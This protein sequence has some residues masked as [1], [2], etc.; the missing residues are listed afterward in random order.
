[1]TRLGN[2]IGA[3]TCG[4]IM[5]HV[6]KVWIT[7]Y[8][9][10]NPKCILLYQ[11]HQ[12][13]ML[14]GCA[15]VANMFDKLSHTCVILTTS[16][17]VTNSV[18]YFMALPFILAGPLSDQTGM[19]KQSPSQYMMHILP[20]VASI[21]LCMNSPLPVTHLARRTSQ[22]FSVASAGSYLLCSKLYHDCNGEGRYVRD[23]SVERRLVVP[24]CA[25]LYSVTRIV[26]RVF[27]GPRN[28][29]WW[30][31]QTRGNALP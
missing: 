7:D 14:T 30:E 20:T 29:K 13:T 11:T 27:T 24:Y 4:C 10:Y 8:K 21:V 3:S 1:M 23:I 18:A 9:G 16:M 28:V 22:S 31:R 5:A 26:L 12:A 25:L 2:T 17:N 6:L 19:I 15:F